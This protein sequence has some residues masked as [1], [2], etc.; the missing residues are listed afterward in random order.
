LPI[1]L[2]ELNDDRL[3]S[4]KDRLDNLFDNF[5]HK[6]T[7]LPTAIPIS[8]DHVKEKNGQTFQ[9]KQFQI[10]VDYFKVIVNEL[11]LSNQSRLWVNTDP[12]VL[13]NTEFGYAGKK[14]VTMPSL[15][16]P[17]GLKVEQVPYGGKMVIK[18][19]PVA[20][21]YPYKGGDLRTTVVLCQLSTEIVVRKIMKL[22]EAVGGALDCS[23]QLSAYLKVAGVV[24]DG[25][26][27]IAG[28]KNGLT[29]ILGYD[30]PFKEP[31]YFALIHLP[32]EQLDEKKLW[33]VNNRLKKGNTP[34]KAEPFND[35]DY[36][37][38]SIKGDTERDDVAYLPFQE[39]YDKIYENASMGD[40]DSWKRA[41]TDLSTLYLTM[42]RCPD[43][44]KQH[45]ELLYN[46]WLKEIEE[47]HKKNKP[48]TETKDQMNILSNE[49]KMDLKMSFKALDL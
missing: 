10:D 17:S 12:T 34:E 42:R 8:S 39:S 36:V 13:V 37:L 40:K 27:E 45:A 46:K 18:D 4:F 14:D 7:V 29:P 19:K 35:A 41:T 49:A 32:I 6:Q 25:I 38:Y 5:L 20:G 15:V 24:V 2:S 1:V 44:T 48:K 23:T 21:Y 3:V 30:C 16:G 43:L 47:V 9:S 28:I 33:V 22:I 26:E 31:G 11:F